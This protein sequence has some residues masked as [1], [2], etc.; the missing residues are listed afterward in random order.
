MAS[1]Q[2]LLQF[3]E[4]ISK[5]T[6]RNKMDINNISMVLA[7]NLF[8]KL[9]SSKLSYN[10]VTLAAKTTHVV[11]LMIRYHHVLWTVSL[12][13]YVHV[14]LCVHLLYL[15]KGREGVCVC[16]CQHLYCM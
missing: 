9:S 6:D 12:R 16:T 5:E 11:L 14:C 10:D 1:L 8:Y 2:C 15:C 7:P 4:K 3:C 13:N